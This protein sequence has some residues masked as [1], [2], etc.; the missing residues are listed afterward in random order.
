MLLVNVKVMPCKSGDGG[1]GSSI[2][3]SCSSSSS[4]S[5]SI[6]AA[7]AAAAVGVTPSSSCQLVSGTNGIIAE[8]WTFYPPV[9]LM[10][11]SV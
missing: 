4:S 2:S 1:G 7:T 5:I 10:S 8:K 3:S 6:V 9:S 11:I